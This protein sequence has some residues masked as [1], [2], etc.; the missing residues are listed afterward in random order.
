MVSR[1]PRQIVGYCVSMD[2]SSRTI[3]KIVDAVPEAETHCIDEYS[4]Y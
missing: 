2:K 1:K 4:R 3:Q